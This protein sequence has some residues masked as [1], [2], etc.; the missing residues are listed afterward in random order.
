MAASTARS[1]SPMAPTVARQGGGEWRRKKGE[2]TATAGK[3]L[4]L[5]AE[6]SKLLIRIQEEKRVVAAA[7]RADLA[8][9]LATV[10]SSPFRSN[11]GL[12]L[13]SSWID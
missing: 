12:I 11:P 13:D 9:S 1:I 2:A 5:V 3:H 10:F 6:A 7:R 4:P 8:E